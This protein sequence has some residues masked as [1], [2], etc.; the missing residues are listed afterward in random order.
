[1]IP[2]L[3]QWVKDPVLPRAV[4]Q[5]AD[6]VWIWCG[7]G[8]GVGLSRSS[9]SAFNLETSICLRCGH[10]KKP[11]NPWSS[12]YGVMGLEES[13][14]RWDAGLI[15]GPA[16]WVK[17]PALQQLQ[18]KLQLWL[19]SDPWPGN[20]ICHK[21]A[22]KVK[23]KNKKQNKRQKNLGG[24]DVPGGLVRSEAGAGWGGRW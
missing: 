2:S 16:Q 3:T 20:C 18:L 6:A 24:S 13:W 5:V 10:K 8:C 9:D 21:V 15:P 7:C 14:K 22:K 1:M 17:D 4:V 23:N 12:C 19:R 11:P